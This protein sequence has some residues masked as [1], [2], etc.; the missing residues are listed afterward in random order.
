MRRRPPRSTQS[1][2]SAASD[3][4]KRQGIQHIEGRQT[5]AGLEFLVNGKLMPHVGWTDD[6]LAEAGRVAAVFNVS[7]APTL[8]KVLP[9]IRRLGVDVAIRF[10]KVTG[11]A[12]IPLA[13]LAAP[14]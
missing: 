8:V 14:V 7:G 12:D 3:V 5:G 13:P 6:S 11:A 2:S 1:R 10:P 9:I 4:Y